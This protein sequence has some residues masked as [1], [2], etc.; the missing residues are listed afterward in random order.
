MGMKEVCLNDFTERVIGLEKF[1]N[2][3]GCDNSNQR[4]RMIKIV[5]N[6]VEGELTC[7]QKDCLFMY[8]E[9][10]MKMA[11]I[12]DNLGICI[13]CVSR[14]IKKAKEKIQKTLSYY[15]LVR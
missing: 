5:K 10:Q 3:Y 2:N 4:R 11:Q 13:S 1:K 14:H 15:Y 6:V 7:R 9:K 12:S 8:Y